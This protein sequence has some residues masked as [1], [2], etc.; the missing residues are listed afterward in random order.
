MKNNNGIEDVLEHETIPV[1]DGGLVF[2]G[3]RNEPKGKRREGSIPFACDDV[4]HLGI[5]R[6]NWL[7]GLAMQGYLS[8]PDNK[9]S[10]REKIPIAQRA[11][12][13]ADAMIEHGNKT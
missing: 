2:P 13:Q 7:A 1:D 8:A 6:R 11:Y 4:K 12:E 9:F 5:S 3:I 10:N